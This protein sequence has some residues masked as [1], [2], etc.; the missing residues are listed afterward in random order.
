MRIS[1]CFRGSLV[2]ILVAVLGF[3]SGCETTPNGA[4]WAARSARGGGRPVLATAHDDTITL[5]GDLPRREN[6]PYAARSR[7]SVKQHTFAEEGADYDPDVDGEGRKMVFASTR[8]T[9]RA[10]LYIKAVDG[11]A[12]MQLTSSPSSDIQPAFSP[13]NQ[14][15]AFASDR[16]GNWDIWIVNI[17][18][19]QPMQVTTGPADDIHASWSPDGL[20]LVYCSR[21]V[22]GGQWELWVVDAVT[23]GKKTFIGYGLFPEWSPVDNTIVFQRARERG[24]RWFS[25][26]TVKLVDGEP[27]HPTEICSSAD[28]AMIL[29]TWSSDGSRIAFTSVGTDTSTDMGRPRAGFSDVWVVQADGRSRIRLTD[30]QTANFAPVIAADGRVYLT[31]DRDGRERIW[32]LPMP[33][34]PLFGDEQLRAEAEPGEA[35]LGVAVLSASNTGSP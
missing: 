25:I 17:D 4:G 16:T 9:Q 2:S 19:I 22:G 11:L 12:V 7:L 21:P 14:R 27:R 5:F 10:D 31:S 8:H 18:G 32:S 33:G 30:G 24:N 6:A 15:V 28:F 26:W 3:M 1:C 35:S 23:A 29:P 20:T 34:A 13:D